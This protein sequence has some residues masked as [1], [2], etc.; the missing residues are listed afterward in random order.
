[1]ENPQVHQEYK[2][3]DQPEKKESILEKIGKLPKFTQ[4]CA[5]AL[6]LGVFLVIAIPS[7]RGNLAPEEVAQ[8][9]TM[10]EEEAEEPVEAEEAPVE[11]VK[12]E[13]PVE[14][15]KVE[16]KAVEAPIT[17]TKQAPLD[18]R[19]LANDFYILISD[20]Y[21]IG[22]NDGAALKQSSIV[23]NI[24]ERAKNC[25]ELTFGGKEL[26]KVILKNID[27]EDVIDVIK[28]EVIND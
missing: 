13:T 5:V 26:E 23:K 6:I 27:C 3:P 10:G 7:L 16:E 1:M 8:E 11:E 24:V 12:E 19:K 2:A 28:E 21:T 9:K 25:E 20:I 22:A 15:P 4:I 17:P 14:E 18:L